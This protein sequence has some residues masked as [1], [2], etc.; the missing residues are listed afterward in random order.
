MESTK[1]WL[2]NLKVRVGW[3]LVGNQSAG[4][5]AYGVSMGTINTAWGT[6]Y[7]ANNYANKDLKRGTLASTSPS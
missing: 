5:Y 3:G 6:G 4:S 1:D 7:Y 2:S